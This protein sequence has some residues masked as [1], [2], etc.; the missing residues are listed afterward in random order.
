MSSYDSW[1]EEPCT[2]GEELEEAECSECGEWLDTVALDS[3]RDDLATCET[4]EDEENVERGAMCS[5]CRA[6]EDGDD[7]D[8]L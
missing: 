3:L 2:R 1:L 7:D 6:K 4:G 5:K 8:Q